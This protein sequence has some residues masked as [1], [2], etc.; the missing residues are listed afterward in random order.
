MVKSTVVDSETGKSKDSRFGLI[1]LLVLKIKA[2]IVVMICEMKTLSGC[3][4]VQGLS[5]GEEGT[6][7]L[8]PLRK[9]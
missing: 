9:E 5:L 4:Q 1:M 7:S 8:R 2:S 6:K 3:G